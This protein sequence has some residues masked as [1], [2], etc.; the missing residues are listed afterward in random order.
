MFKSKIRFTPPASHVELCLFIS[1]AAASCS[2]YMAVWGISV[3][4]IRLQLE[5]LC[6]ATLIADTDTD[7]YLNSTSRNLED[8]GL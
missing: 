1:T 7:D 6:E 8:W 3:K 2:D 4:N 5:K